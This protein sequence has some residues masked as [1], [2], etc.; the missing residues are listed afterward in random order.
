MAQVKNSFSSIGEVEASVSPSALL[1]KISV[2]NNALRYFVLSQTHQQI[3]FFGDYTLHHVAN[4]TELAQRIEKIFKKDEI[5]QLQ[6]SKILIGLDE[7]YS[8]VPTEF[9]FMINR[10]DQ[11]T[12]Q[13]LGTEIAYESSEQLVQTLKNLFVNAELLHLNSTY[14]KYLTNTAGKLFVNV[15]ASHLDIIRFDSDEK[16]KLMNRY[17]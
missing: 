7:K 9:S 11:L 12:Q 16:L 4:A 17:D 10:N 3:I 2:T 13:C 14:F 15:S 1:L 5:L 8:L 6:F